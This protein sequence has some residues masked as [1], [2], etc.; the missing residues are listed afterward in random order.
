MRNHCCFFPDWQRFS[1]RFVYGSVQERNQ[2][3]PR[4]LLR[5]KL[6]V[7][8]VLFGTKKPRLF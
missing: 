8:A 1:F 7:A 4:E 6:L 5:W 3:L 2:K